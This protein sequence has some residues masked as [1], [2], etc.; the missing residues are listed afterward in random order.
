MGEEKRRPQQI[1][2]ERVERLPGGE[3]LTDRIAKLTHLDRST[4]D[5]VSVVGVGEPEHL[6]E[7]GALRRNLHEETC[8]PHSRPRRIGDHP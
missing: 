6:V 4:G 7:V 1:E 5:P 2:V 8:L 3:E